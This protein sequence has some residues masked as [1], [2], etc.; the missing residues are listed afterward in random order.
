MRIAIDIRSTLKRKTGIGYYTLNLINHLSGIDR[1]NSYYLY[2]DVG[3]FN[4]T[5]KLPL[6]PGKNF[7]H[8]INRFKMSE[9]NFFKRA[10]I[11]HTQSYD[12]RFPVNLKVVLV[13]HDLMHRAYPVGQTEE[14]LKK[15]KLDMERVLLRA[16]KI[17]VSS[18]ST[19]NDLIKFYAPDQNKIRLIYPGASE[20]LLREP[21]LSQEEKKSLKL[22]FGITSPFL[23]YVGTLEPRKNLENLIRAF[24]IVKDNSDDLY[25]LVLAGMRGW[26]YDGIF[27]LVDEFNLK[28][29]VIFT[30]YVS[31]PELKALYELADMFVYPSFYE[32]VGLPI[33]EAF[34]FGLPVVTSKSSSLSEIAGD[35]AI[36]ADPFKFEEI[37]ES[38]LRIIKDSKFKNE[39]KQKGKKRL[40]DFTWKSAAEKT[41]ETFNEC[42]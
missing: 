35:A 5:K 33:L 1:T 9:E 10:D 22:K 19:H 25:Q 29:S 37:A 15:I 12:L 24:Q 4:R 6:L 34:L 38:I 26:G 41:L 40:R 21:S 13:V 42:A 36:T 18:R 39:L 32:G 31:R 11:V 30:D 14:S 16:D 23:L 28:K 8:L 2:S 3:F 20:D 17:I 7:K 27:K